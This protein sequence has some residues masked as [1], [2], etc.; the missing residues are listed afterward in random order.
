MALA[1][2]G[3]VNDEWDLSELHSDMKWN[4]GG[5]IRLG[6]D[7]IVVRADVAMGD[8]DAQVQMFISHTF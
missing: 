6:V 7:G 3:R 1:E 5:G 4:L 2:V 8:E